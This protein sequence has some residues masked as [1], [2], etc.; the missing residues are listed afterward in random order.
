M[1]YRTALFFLF[2]YYI[3]PQDWIPSLIGYNIIRP[4]ILVWIV[5]FLSSRTR[6]PVSGILKTPHDWAMLAYYGYI[7]WNSADSNGTFKAFLPFVVFY[8]FTI[9]SLTSWER[10]LG[11]LKFWNLM[12]LGVA[13]MA[14]A[15]LYGMDLTGARDMTE[16]FFGRLCIGTWL[17]DNPNALAH[18]T[19]VAIPLSYLF[20]FWKKGVTGR[21]VVFPL[22]AVLAG[23]CVYATESKGSFIVGA[24][25]CV[26]LFVIGRPK[27]VQIFSITMAATLGV[28]ALSFL[29]RMEKMGN[30][31]ED[32]GVQGRLMV[33]E[34][35]RQVT[36]TKPT[37]EGWGQFQG[38]II[39][40]GRREN[41]A[42]HSSYVQIGA[43][44]GVDG[45]FCYLL[46]L[47][48][49][50]R[51][52]LVSAKITQEFPEHERCRRAAMILLISYC[53]SGWMINRQ[54]HH[55]YFLII[56]VTAAIHRLNLAEQKRA[57]LALQAEEASENEGESLDVTTEGPLTPA[58]ESDSE[59]PS[60]VLVEL[61]NRGK[62]LWNRLSLIDVGVGVAATWA[63]LFTWDY[64][65][66][67][68]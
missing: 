9:H 34:M 36:R 28:S 32:E 19:V 5:S 54:Y 18:S 61:L 40:E 38:Y 46:L 13:F 51:S 7:V 1:E 57:A 58:P 52:L 45:L 60:P 14:V 43:D 42:T 55:E 53:I 29:P 37:G 56:A 16:M 59:P 20:Y 63:V 64:V 41:K 35:A 68:L 30:L 67:N 6:S 25:L 49:A 47:W 8:F 4:L 10:V 33:W 23:H 62:K 31:R 15:S 22:C 3:R 27:L 26:L 11:Y 17:H 48:L 44:L 12:L 21:V 39:W 66:K 65:L 2:L 24:V 50:G